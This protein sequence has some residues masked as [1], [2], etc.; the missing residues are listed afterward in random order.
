[1][2]KH[3]K[4]QENEN[5][6]NSKWI[7]NGNGAAKETF[8]TNLEFDENIFTEEEKQVV[9]IIAERFLSLQHHI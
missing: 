1:M 3:T 6:I 2:K 5:I 8:I 9:E 4:I 7:R